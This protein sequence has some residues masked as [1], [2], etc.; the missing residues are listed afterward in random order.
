MGDCVGLRVQNWS[1]VIPCFLM[2]GVPPTVGRL[3]NL[4][5][6]EVP[7]PQVCWLLPEQSLCLI[8]D[9]L[10]VTPTLLSRERA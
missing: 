7:S 3:P 9:P 10:F 1:F 5:F 4:H 8:P 6:L 2:W